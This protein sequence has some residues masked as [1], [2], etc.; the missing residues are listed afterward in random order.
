[1]TSADDFE[2]DGWTSLWL[3]SAVNVKKLLKNKAETLT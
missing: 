3:K 1:M 2:D